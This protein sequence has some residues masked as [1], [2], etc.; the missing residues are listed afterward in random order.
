MR[1]W[2]H[3]P[4]PSF[5]TFSYGFLSDKRLPIVII[6]L[7]AFAGGFGIGGIGS[8]GPVPIS[9]FNSPIPNMAPTLGFGNITQS[10][11][12]LGA[13]LSTSTTPLPASPFTSQVWE[14]FLWSSVI[15]DILFAV[16]SEACHSWAHNL[17]FVCILLTSGVAGHWTHERLLLLVFYS[18][19][20][21]WYFIL[22]VFSCSFLSGSLGISLMNLINHS[23]RSFYNFFLNWP[24]VSNLDV[25]MGIFLHTLTKVSFS[26]HDLV[27]MFSWNRM[28]FLQV[29]RNLTIYKEL[30]GRSTASGRWYLVEGDMET[31]RGM[32]FCHFAV[33]ICTIS[34]EDMI[35]LNS[36][37]WNYL[38]IL[39]T[40]LF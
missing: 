30:S 6:W 36:L 7:F 35:V 14:F 22:F 13:S 20:L 5:I 1:R 39:T 27:V 32:S 40:P 15:Q 28:F 18:S 25:I 17:V 21:S 16:G 31:R 19:L 37:L 24:K 26:A 8:A 3:G 11:P 23:M 4:E 10:P 2:H 33:Y 29:A 38:A 34:R 9:P 12:P